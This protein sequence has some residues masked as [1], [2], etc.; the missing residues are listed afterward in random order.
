MALTSGY[1]FSTTGKED[2]G[3]AVQQAVADAKKSAPSPSLA[4]VSCT[5]DCDVDAVC[6]AFKAELGTVPFHGVTSS[7]GLLSTAGAVPAGIGCL[8]IEAS[9]ADGLVHASSATGDAVKAA[10][11]LKAAVGDHSPQAILLAATPGAEEGAL[12][13][14]AK[15]FGGEVPVFGGTA[16]DN[17]LSGDWKVL[18]AAGATANGVS[19]V[20]VGAGIKF[21]AS[22]T[23][24][25]VPTDLTCTATK[26][27]GRRVFT[28][29][30]KPA[31]DFAFNW[32]GDSVAKEYAEGGLVLPQTAQKPIGYQLPSGE[33]ISMHLAAFGGAE[34]HVDFF[35]PVPEG[36]K[37]TIMSSGNGPS[38]GYA[39]AIERAFDKAHASL[40]APAACGML[41]FCG[42]MAIAVGDNLNAGLTSAGVVEK[43]GSI[44]L[45][46]MTCF[47]EQCF[48][49][50]SKVS[51]QRNLS[52]GFLLF[53]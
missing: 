5:V 20:A 8:L 45:L 35:T 41:I 3:K 27:E 31:A 26:T 24:P 52:V 51:V 7:G 43:A 42:G 46:G 39:D 28:I 50:G 16:A 49:P 21:G 33:W 40:G 17:A 34:K 32:L 9:S 19:L 10:T 11:E 1:G 18:T 6:A 23:G 48:M 29:D 22:M 44:P 30:D 15:V 47:G 14:V 13:E 36:A 38:T 12:A 37:L 25:Y 2:P 53:A 4:F